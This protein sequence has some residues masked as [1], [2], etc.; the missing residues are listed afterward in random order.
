MSKLEN[1]MAGSRVYNYNK[2]EE[3]DRE[4]VGDELISMGVQSAVVTGIDGDFGHSTNICFFYSGNRRS[5]HKLSKQSKLKEGDKVNVKS[6]CLITLSREGDKDSE[7]FDGEKLQY[8]YIR[9]T[10]CN[11]PVFLFLLGPESLLHSMISSYHLFN[12]PIYKMYAR[13]LFIYRA[14]YTQLPRLIQ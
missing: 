14:H 4:P 12:F 2:F 5:F 9:S 13:T 3:T 10:G 8:I 6:I 7:V 11:I 1:V